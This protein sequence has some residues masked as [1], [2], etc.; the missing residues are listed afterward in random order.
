MHL[1]VLCALTM[2]AFA[3]NSVLTRMGVALGGTDAQSFA[4]IRLVA[5]AAT[6]GA[7]LALR[8][9][10]WPG[11]SGPMVG[12]AG[13]LTYLFGFSAAYV[14]LGAGAGALILF[15]CV[16]I[17][18][19]AGAVLGRDNIPATRWI[20][21]ALAF[22]GLVWLTLPGLRFG[23]LAPM[24]FMALAGVGWGLYSL[25]GRHAHDP[26]AATGWNFILAVPPA[27]AIWVL[28]SPALIDGQGV[29][30]AVLSGAVTSGLGYALWYRLLP[31]LGA[32][33]A[34]VAQLSVPVLAAV[35]GLG[36]GEPLTWRFIVAAAV[37]LA[38]VA[39]ASKG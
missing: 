22:G 24:G 17:T 32:S 14:G 4:L 3:A 29:G 37:V 9:S 26:L 20:G 5:G 7:I 33:R 10:V 28:G 2:L 39:V 38:G 27:L 21:T 13:L 11:W 1:F 35:G 18:M 15:G 23:G 12:V 31:S 36:L 19:F 34:A 6:L 30:L 8:R 16:Q 25:A